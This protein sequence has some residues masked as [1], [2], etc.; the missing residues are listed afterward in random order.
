MPLNAPPSLL[1]RIATQAIGFLVFLVMPTA[2]TLVAP[3][4][5]IEFRHTDGGAAVTVRRYALTFVHWQ[6]R[7]IPDV[8]EL[9]PETTAEFRYR[10]TAENRRKGRAGTTSYATGQLVVVSAGPDVI[11]QAAPELV[12]AV[13]TRFAQFRNNKAEPPLTLSVYASWN[14]SYLLGGAMTALA[15]FYVVCV[16]LAG[17]ARLLRAVGM[18]S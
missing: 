8:Q 13:S 11:V 6:T 7:R 14:L 12:H 2:I 10:D 1:G 17:M 4:T 16:F 3:F 5:D 18:R 9:L 15:A